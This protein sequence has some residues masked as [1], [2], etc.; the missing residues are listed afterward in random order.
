VSALASGIATATMAAM[1]SVKTGSIAHRRTLPIMIPL[2]FRTR[3][4]HYRS[5][6]FMQT[7]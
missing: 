4:P 1:I 2:G 3:E 5:E 7:N 6:M